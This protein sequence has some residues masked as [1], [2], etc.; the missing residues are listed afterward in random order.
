MSPNLRRLVVARHDEHLMLQWDGTSFD[1][2][3]DSIPVGPVLQHVGEAWHLRDLRVDVVQHHNL[4]SIVAVPPLVAILDKRRF[5]KLL[6][7]YVSCLVRLAS[8]WWTPEP[9]STHPLGCVD[10]GTGKF[11]GID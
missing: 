11:E 10:F 6:L 3:S 7:G 5:T 9:K 8:V 4:L 1:L 2:S